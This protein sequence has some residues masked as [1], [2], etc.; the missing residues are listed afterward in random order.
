MRL[1]DKQI[2]WIAKDLKKRGLTY[3]PLKEELLDHITAIAETEDEFFMPVVRVI[4]H[5]IPQ[6]RSMANRHYPLP[7]IHKRFPMVIH[8]FALC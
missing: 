8:H 3:Q 2:D 6:D 7:S 4:T 1:S 5:E